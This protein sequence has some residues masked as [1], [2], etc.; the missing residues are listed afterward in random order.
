MLSHLTYEK[1]NIVFSMEKPVLLAEIYKD[2]A[3]EYGLQFVNQQTRGGLLIRSVDKKLSMNRLAEG[4]FVIHT[5]CESDYRL[6]MPSPNVT[7]KPL[8]SQVFN[9]TNNF[10]SIRQAF[11]NPIVF[12]NLSEVSLDIYVDLW[13]SV[14][15]NIGRVVEHKIVWEKTFDLN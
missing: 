2:T 10:K 4:A 13:R 8:M 7:F 1:R 6:L 5:F 9:N 11:T 12:G 3:I 15:A 14:G